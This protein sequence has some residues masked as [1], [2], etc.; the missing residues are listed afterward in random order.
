MEKIYTV[1]PWTMARWKKIRREMIALI[2]CVAAL[3]FLDHFVQAG[4]WLLVH[5]LAK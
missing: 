2:V 1:R 4:A 5:N 3:V